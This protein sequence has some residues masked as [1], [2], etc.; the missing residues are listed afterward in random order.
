[1]EEQQVLGAKLQI[2]GAQLQ[3]LGALKTLGVPPP[4]IQVDI[5]KIKHF[6]YR[7]L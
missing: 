3:T 7:F 6:F 5:N 1:M 4:V 2:L